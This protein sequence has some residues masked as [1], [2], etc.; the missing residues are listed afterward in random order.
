MADNSRMADAATRAAAARAEAMTPKGRRRAFWWGVRANCIAAA[1]AFGRGTVWA[2][3][4]LPTATRTTLE[5]AGFCLALGFI[6]V[7]T[8]WE[9][10]N[11]GQGWA[12]IF[13]AWG[14]FAW[15]AGVSV[16][17]WAI[18][19]HRQHKEHGRSAEAFK[20]E[21][22]RKEERA[23]RGRSHK[24]MLS[25]FLCALVTLF[26][27]FSNLVSHSAMSAQEAVELDED[28]AVMRANVRRLE[29]EYGNLPKPSGVEFT[30]ETLASYISEAIGWKMA[31]LDDVAPDPAPEG[32]PGP[33][34]KADLKKRPRELCKLASD[35]RAELKE[36]A[37]MQVALDAKQKDIDAEKTKLDAMAPATGAKHWQQMAELWNSLPGVPETS[38]GFIQTWGV[39][40][41]SVFG[42]FVCFIGWDSVGERV[43][44]RRVTP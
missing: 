39:F 32:Y 4:N 34:C 19:S 10:N 31:N 26:G 18:W 6:G 20:D 3:K 15:I 8:A 35:I 2:W 24:W 36:A 33:G 9:L 23:A 27:V 44:K 28:R 43:E 22:N 37:E 1:I 13:A 38:P 41:V 7:I 11:S 21:G 40:L 17:G 5:F 25:S 29:R 14:S 30:K 16:A 12:L 42:L